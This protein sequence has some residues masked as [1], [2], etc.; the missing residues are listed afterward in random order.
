MFGSIFWG[1]RVIRFSFGEIYIYVEW[2]LI[3]MKFEIE[4][5]D[6]CAGGKMREMV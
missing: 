3:E 5:L 6:Y 4:G 2:F 1:V